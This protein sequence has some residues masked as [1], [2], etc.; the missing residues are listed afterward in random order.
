MNSLLRKCL[1]KFVMCAVAI[2]AAGYCHTFVS[3]QTPVVGAPK[4]EFPQSP[5]QWIQGRPITLENLK[6]K[7]V[8][9]WFFE[10]QC[11]NCRKKWP[12]L[13]AAAKKYEGQPVLFIAV[14]SGTAR[15]V[16]EA[17]NRETPVKWPILVDQSRDFEKLCNVPEVTLE[18]VM[19]CRVITPNGKLQQ[20]SWSDIEGSMEL[21]AKGAAWKV[22]PKIVPASLK[23]MWE[24]VEFGN[25][26]TAGAS[27]KKALTTGPADSRQ[28][29]EKIKAVVQAE[30]AASATIAKTAEDKGDVWLAYKQ[31]GELGSRFLG[32]DIPTEVDAARKKL[33]DNTDVKANLSAQRELDSA[34]KLFNTAS[35]INHKKAI[36]M[37]EKLVK[38]SGGT[39]AGKEAEGILAQAG[40]K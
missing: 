25:Y 16:I 27:L 21:A 31:Y 39:E 35:N 23:P 22:D 17:Y 37:L 14:N 5:T 19:Q 32:F 30:I 15:P 2:M 20:G 9:L 29:A 34:K 3:A 38:D 13:Q 26:T 40:Q 1:A 24:A 10:E 33:S 8:F 28:A 4:L 12:D 7:G 18:N 11:P 36:G 6:G